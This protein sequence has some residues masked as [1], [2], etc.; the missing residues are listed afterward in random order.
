M[1]ALYFV[2][3][4]NSLAVRTRAVNCMKVLRES[5]LGVRLRLGEFVYFTS[6]HLY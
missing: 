5:I 2:G 4:A 6:T 1:H 3:P